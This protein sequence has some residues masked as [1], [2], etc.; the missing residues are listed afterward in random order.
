MRIERLDFFRFPVPFKVVFRHASASRRRAENL[1][2]AA[3]SEDGRTGYG[4]GCPRSYVSG[5]TPGSGLAFLAEHA[6]ALAAEVVDVDSLRAWT[7]SRREVIDRNPAAFCALETAVLDLFGRVEGRPVEDLVGVPRLTGSFQYSAVLGDAPWPVYRWQLRRYRKW[8]MRDFKLKLSGDPRRDR[9][10]LRA[11][12]SGEPV[13][14]RLDANNLWTSPDECIRHLRGLPGAVFAVE[15]PLRPGDIEGFERV[16]RECGARIVLDESL[17][18]ADQ[19]GALQDPARW[20]ANLR[21]SKLGGI[22]RSL[23]V[24]AKAAERG[25][26]VIVGAQV[27]ETSILA[28]AALTLMRAAG[29]NLIASEGAFGT[30]LLQSDLTSPSLMFG[31]GGLLDAEPWSD[32][33]NGGLGLE[34]DPGGL[35]PAAAPE[36]A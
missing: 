13:R 31:S 26:G 15:E 8:G 17:L 1:I 14:V 2:V 25:V 33:G 27:G 7:R 5:E 24:A 21:V 11:F 20:I 32:P 9:G 35:V 12:G 34:I 16:G 4:E 30:H 19:L 23:E 18:R 6:P 22:L 29:P 10:K 36:P 3:R 28:R